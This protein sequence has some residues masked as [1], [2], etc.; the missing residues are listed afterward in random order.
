[1]RPHEQI[2]ENLKHMREQAEY[3][4]EPVAVEVR[5]Y[6]TWARQTLEGVNLYEEVRPWLPQEHSVS[7]LRHDH[8]LLT[9][10]FDTMDEAK[11]YIH[12][13]PWSVAKVRTN[14]WGVMY[15]LKHPNAEL[16]IQLLLRKCTMRPVETGETRPVV[17]WEVDCNPERSSED[18]TR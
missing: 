14:E 4:P 12:T 13:L 9:L 10:W 18:G 3:L 17:R 1:M 16:N 7:L 8:A 2:L 11:E 6:L 15:E 5:Q